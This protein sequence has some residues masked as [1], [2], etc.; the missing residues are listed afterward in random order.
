MKATKILGAAA[1][2]VLGGLAG[3]GEAKVF[4]YTATLAT[5]VAAPGMVRAGVFNWKCE[6]TSCSI[7]GP[8]AEPAVG[9]CKPLAKQVGKITAFGHPEAQLDAKGLE[10]CNAEV[11]AAKP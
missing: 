6:G 7:N 3:V 4:Q 8:W 11:P 10:E 5:P 9:H 1:V 2:L